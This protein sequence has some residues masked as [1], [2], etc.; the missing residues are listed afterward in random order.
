M[1]RKLQSAAQVERAVSEL[2]MAIELATKHQNPE[3]QAIFRT[4]SRV[5]LASNLAGLTKARVYYWRAVLALQL[6]YLDQAASDVKRA[7]A[8]RPGHAQAYALVAELANRRGQFA[9]CLAAY[10]RAI[11]LA[12]SNANWHFNRANCLTKMGRFAE[13]LVD[14]EKVIAIDAAHLG[15]LN[16]RA[17]AL[18]RLGNWDAALVSWDEAVRV[19]P[20]HWPSRIN[21]AA[22]WIDKGEFA[23]AEREFKLILEAIPDQFQALLGLATVYSAGKCYNDALA[24]YER[25]YSIEPKHPFL[26]GHVLHHRLQL[27]HWDGHQPLMEALKQA[28]SDG[29]MACTPFALLALLDNPELHLKNARRYADEMAWVG[30]TE[31]PSFDRLI[32]IQQPHAASSGRIRV[33]YF[34]SD[35]HEHATAYLMAE[36]LETHDRSRF[37]VFVF[38]YGKQTGDL[39]QSRIAQAVEHWLDVVNE[40]DDAIAAEAQRLCLDIAV[41]LKGYTFNSRP[42]LFARRLAPIQINYLG[43]PGTMGV[44]F[45]DYIVADRIT[46]PIDKLASTFS[47]KVVRMPYCY[48]VNSKEISDGATLSDLKHDDNRRLLRRKN[49]LDEDG[50]VY[51]CFNNNYKILPEVFDDWMAILREVPSSSLWLLQVDSPTS[52][53]LKVHAAQSGVDPVRLIFAMR[54]P[55]QQHLARQSLADLFL[56]TF[57]YNAHTTASDALRCG[58]PLITRYGQSFA[59]RVST[60]LLHTLGMQSLSVSDRDAYK[61]LAIRFGQNPSSLA[62]LR[63]SLI[64]KVSQSELFC[65]SGVRPWLEQAYESMVKMRGKGFAPRSFDLEPSGGI[66][67][68]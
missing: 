11:G 17:L 50:F 68:T 21:R 28:I 58:L 59:S 36:L 44:S 9:D 61:A 46:V 14:Y 33:G 47:E 8:E 66:T 62:N 52:E 31:R 19:N 26:L 38:S 40:N 18:K 55:R 13:A 67:I 23:Q 2:R 48:Q 37:E 65:A 35:M 6:D 43:Y 25:A 64:D 7:I 1:S 15:G 12:P 29:Q 32:G 42:G 10:D 51:C 57:P 22:L 27:G 39:F 49:G 63:E 34:S 20:K 24:C 4:Y 45:I 30:P 3:A 41:D 16:H 54:V 5:D 56:D 53:R 60:S